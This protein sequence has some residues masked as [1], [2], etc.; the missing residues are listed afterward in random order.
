MKV[1]STMHSFEMVGCCNNIMF[2]SS[3]KN[4]CRA[5]VRSRG[6]PPGRPHL[7]NLPVSAL[8]KLLLYWGI[9]YLSISKHPYRPL[10]PPLKELPCS[11]YFDAPPQASL[12]HC[13]LWR[14]FRSPPL[15]KNQ[16]SNIL[17]VKFLVFYVIFATERLSV[18][19]FIWQI[20]VKPFVKLQ[21][22]RNILP[23]LFYIPYL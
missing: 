2:N 15:N 7:L 22:P 11:T 20:I 9:E 21:V 19:L 17:F 1:D 5:T 14:N 16:V 13:P 18:L 3:N 6:S 12:I 23:S 4:S 10:S 8:F